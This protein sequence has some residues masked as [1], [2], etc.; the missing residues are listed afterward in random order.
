MLHVLVQ[1][2]RSYC[3]Y[4]LCHSVLSILK[5]L[6]NRYAIHD[7]TQMDLIK[8]SNMYHWDS[9]DANLTGHSGRLSWHWSLPVS[10]TSLS[11]YLCASRLPSYAQDSL[12]SYFYSLS[13]S[14]STDELIVELTLWSISWCSLSSILGSW[15]GKL[16]VILC[17]KFNLTANVKFVFH[18]SRF[19][20]QS[21]EV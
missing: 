3:N 1:S 6:S 13:L 12:S 5:K 10:L 2:F 20:G 18:Y 16:C 11:L 8:V 17:L 14:D 9:Y 15:Q 19:T 4:E 7:F 21:S